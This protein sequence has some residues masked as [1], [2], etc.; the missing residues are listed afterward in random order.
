[1]V[2]H[3]SNDQSNAV[4]KMLDWEIQKKISK[5]NVLN[6]VFRGCFT[7]SE[8]KS[9]SLNRNQ[10]HAIIVNTNERPGHHWLCLY[11]T[12][13]NQRIVIFDSRRG[14]WYLDNTARQYSK[15]CIEDF[16]TNN[17]IEV[18]SNNCNLQSTSTTICGYYCIYVLKL[19]VRNFALDTIISTIATN[20]IATEEGLMEN[21]RILMSNLINIDIII[22]EA[23]NQK[24]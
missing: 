18:V 15:A 12:S 9:L 17:S 11:F 23:R 3:K 13:F 4:S 7:P 16:V 6:H 19:L 20:N 8:I 2:R 10:D 14:D 21:D 5:D 24:N 22:N 1:M